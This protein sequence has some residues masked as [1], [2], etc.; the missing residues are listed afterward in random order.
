MDLIRHIT[1]VGN[2]AEFLYDLKEMKRYQYTP[3]SY[4]EEGQLSLLLMACI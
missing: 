2:Q 4:F 3:F 1:Q